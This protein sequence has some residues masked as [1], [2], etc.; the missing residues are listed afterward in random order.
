M[1]S[2]TAQTKLLEKSYKHISEAAK[3]PAKATNSKA[4]TAMVHYS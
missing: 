2:E 3:A 4:M 1:T